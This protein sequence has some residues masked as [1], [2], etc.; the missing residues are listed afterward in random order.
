M[1]ISFWFAHQKIR[2]WEL[3]QDKHLHFVDSVHHQNEGGI[4]F[5]E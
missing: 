2:W 4:P 3:D 1:P 5:E